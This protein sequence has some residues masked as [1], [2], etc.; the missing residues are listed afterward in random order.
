M[1]VRCCT[2]GTRR[3]TRV[4]LIAHQRKSGH[5]RPCTCGG[6][7]FPHRP[8]SP[9]CDDHPYVRYN[10]ALREKATPDELLDAF[11]DDALFNKHPTTTQ[12]EAPF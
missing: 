2:C 8:G 3:A 10:R 7:H 1:T 5:G 9:N 12:N 4:S 11:I 6:Y